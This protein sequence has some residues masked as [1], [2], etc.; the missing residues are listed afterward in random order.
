[1]TMRI[2]DTFTGH[3]VIGSRPFLSIVVQNKF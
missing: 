1:M 2:E 3:I